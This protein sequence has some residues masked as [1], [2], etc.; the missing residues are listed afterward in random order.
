VVNE[1]GNV[2]NGT[3]AKTVLT[4]STGQAGIEVPRDRDGSSGAAD[5]Q[6]A[7]AAA[8]RGR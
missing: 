4:E 6:E 1:A 3:R 7:A 5:R 8:D 2:R